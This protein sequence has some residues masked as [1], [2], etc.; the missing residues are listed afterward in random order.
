[1]TSIKNDYSLLRPFDLAAA[2][3]GEPICCLSGTSYHPRD[4]MAGPDARGW[5]CVKYPDGCFDICDPVQ[6]HM[7]PLA[8]VEGKPVYKG[9]VLYPT[10]GSKD[11]F[12][13]TGFVD[14]CLVATNWHFNP[15]ALTW[16]PPKVK[17][18]GW[19]VTSRGD[20]TNCVITKAIWPTEA[21]AK[22]A[23]SVGKLLTNPRITRIEWEE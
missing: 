12:R 6:Y 15:S 21:D 1:M 14:G 4:Y 16:N 11:E 23:A 18:E 2:K 9:D 22:A 20:A 3:S 5:I 13:V 19:I 7:A 17:R 10:L 8:W